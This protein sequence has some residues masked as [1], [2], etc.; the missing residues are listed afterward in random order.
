MRTIHNTTGSVAKKDTQISIRESLK[1]ASS[2]LQAPHIVQEALV[3]KIAIVSMNPKEAVDLDKPLAAYVMDSLVTVEMRNS[4]TDEM[5]ANIRALKFIVSS[6]LAR[7]TK[8]ISG[9]S[10]FVGVGA[11]SAPAR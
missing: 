7:I 6:S 2:L 1:Q 4:I 8:V 5:P 11:V 3:G 10:T 9:K